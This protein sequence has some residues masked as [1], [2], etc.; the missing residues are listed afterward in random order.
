MASI[1]AVQLLMSCSF[2]Y[3]FSPYVQ[4]TGYMQ[5]FVFTSTHTQGHILHLQSELVHSREKF[6]WFCW[7]NKLTQEQMDPHT[8]GEIGIHLS[9]NFVHAFLEVSPIK[10]KSTYLWL[11]TCRL[12]MLG[13]HVSWYENCGRT[14]VCWKKFRYHWQNL[15]FSTEWSRIVLLIKSS[16]GCV[17]IRLKLSI[18]QLLWIMFQHLEPGYNFIMQNL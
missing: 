18:I 13:K 10:F 3:L 12:M 5:T 14:K 2:H 11:D 4:G 17:L 6:S 16:L 9:C 8:F 15:K 1:P 7:V